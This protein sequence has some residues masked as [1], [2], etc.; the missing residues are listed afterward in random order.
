MGL[1]MARHC[2]QGFYINRAREST[3]YRVLGSANGSRILM[4]AQ[5]STMG[6][7]CF[8]NFVFQLLSAIK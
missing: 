4:E 6:Q 7:F 5:V 8:L 2:T 3:F 1:I